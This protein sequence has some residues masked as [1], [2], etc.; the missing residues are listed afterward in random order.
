[1][2]RINKFLLKWNEFITVPIG[3]LLVFYCEP[4]IVYFFPETPRYSAGFLYDII[5]TIA[6]WL[7]FNGVAYF[8]FK[9]NWPGIEKYIDNHAEEHFLKSQ[10]SSEWI[11][12]VLFI[13]YPL[14]LILTAL[15][16]F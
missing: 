15:A 14:S 4:I 11:P 10:T 2:K 5:Y 6:T 1:M 3:L 12:I 9:I 13:W 8:I 16:V 7:I